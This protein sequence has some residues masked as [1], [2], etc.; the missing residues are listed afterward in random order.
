MATLEN[1]PMPYLTPPQL[2]ASQLW[3]IDEQCNAF[4]QAFQ[5][6]QEPRAEQF[7][8]KVDEP[9]R[10]ILLPELLHLELH[11]RSDCSRAELGDRFPQLE[12]TLL[13]G[14]A[15]NTNDDQYPLVPGYFLMEELGRGGMGIV[16]LAADLTLHR[17]VALKMLHRSPQVSAEH[18]RRFLGEARAAARL[19]HPNLVPIFDSGEVDG[20]PFLVF[21]L[22]EGGTLAERLRGKPLTFQ[23]SA[24][25]METLS[26][27]I[28]FAHDRHILHRDLK[29]SNVLLTKEGMPRIGDFGL[30]KR[31][32][33][34]NFQTTSG[35]V[36]GTPSYMAPEQ[37]G[38][39]ANASTAAVDVYSL[40]AILYELLTGRPPFKAASLMETLDQVRSMEP[41]APHRIRDDIPPDLETI[42]L[43]CLQKEPAQRYISAQVLAEEL[44]RFQRG[45]SIIARPVSTIERAGRWCKRHPL[46]T[47]LA[48]AVVVVAAFGFAGIWWQWKEADVQRQ[49][50]ESN[51]ADYRGE[52]DRA[53][54]A[55]DEALA[56][57]AEARHQQHMA[58]K[59][60]AAAESRFQKAQG[61]IQEL[62]LLG[63]ELVHQP[64]M[65]A[66]GR[67]AMEK[68]TEFR[69][70]L[71]EE[72]SDDPKV[73]C[74]TAKAIGML[75]WASLEHGVFE[76][77]EVGYQQARDIFE[78]LHRQDPQNL[79]YL[80][81]LVRACRERG[82]TLDH[83][84]RP[85]EAEQACRASVDYAEKV[86]ATGKSSYYD[87]IVL[88][89][90]LTN[91]AGRLSAVGRRQEAFAAVQR[92]V[93]L[94]RDAIAHHPE[95]NHFR[96]SLALALTNIAVHMW[97][98]D[99]EAS[100]AATEEA[101]EIR[102]AQVARTKAP[103]DEAMY[104][105]RALNQLS[106]RYIALGRHE[107]AEQLVAEAIEHAETA[108]ASFPAFFGVRKHHIRTLEDARQIAEKKAD[109]VEA[110]AILH[111]LQQEVKTAVK[112]FPDDITMKRWDAFYPSQQ[113]MILANR[114]ENEEAMKLLVQSLEDLRRLQS[115]SSNPGEFRS[116]ILTVVEGFGSVGSR[117]DFEKEKQ[118]AARDWVAQDP[119]SASAH[120]SLAWRLAFVQDKTLRD[121]VAA[122]KLVRRAIEL[123]PDRPFYHNTLGVAL[124]YQ[125]RLEDAAAEFERSQ[126]LKTSEPAADWFYLAM[127]RCRLGDPDAANELQEKAQSWF[128]EHRPNDEELQFILREVVS[129]VGDPASVD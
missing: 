25:L 24:E 86:I 117:F 12:Q 17:H 115:E 78:E 45:E 94:H 79:I 55:T 98:K 29:P 63:I 56:H 77:A 38:G 88:G 39:L 47:S 89:N 76:E 27:A 83:L 46:P 81:D 102:R 21:E 33:D 43:K 84:L 8:A 64:K 120:N 127:I 105:I 90:A 60:L 112:E 126:E 119:D 72:K 69:Q 106:D 113:A 116:N 23:E 28:Q 121:A 129:V 37:A 15:G 35:Q 11:Y 128:K 9:L 71:L 82:I 44:A 70:A 107:E 57:A 3:Q 1:P 93:E 6:G 4:E 87:Q 30:A 91:W 114:G 42:C 111:R 80:R 16:Y 48:A 59:Y 54:R 75:A 61:P 85:E 92:S 58:E 51:A 95:L 26:R 32:D 103:R 49:L 65:E 10:N 62:I 18:R 19:H 50:A 52:R 36:F 34:D 124:Y 118:E 7:L 40:G 97:S 125:D 101:V 5:S 110:E 74:D 2:T 122:E 96:E 109:P 123:R 31:L 20:H 67:Q 41:T 100:V 22:V 66:R 108:K 99:R 68:A 73:R 53:I 13:D 14:I 104:L